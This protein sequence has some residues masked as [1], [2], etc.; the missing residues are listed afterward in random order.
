MSPTRDGGGGGGEAVSRRGSGLRRPAGTPA[1]P[2]DF[3]NHLA[4][5]HAR[6]LPVCQSAATEL[7]MQC[8]VALPILPQ[9]GGWR[10]RLGYLGAFVVVVVP[11]AREM[12]F[13]PLSEAPN[14]SST[15]PRQTG[16]AT[17]MQK[18]HRG[19]RNGTSPAAIDTGPVRR[20][21][22]MLAVR[23]PRRGSLGC[24]GARAWTWSVPQRRLRSEE[25]GPYAAGRAW[26]RAS[27]APCADSRVW[28]DSPRCPCPTP[29]DRPTEPVSQPASQ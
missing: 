28:R 20:G 23:A 26:I 6:S 14:S 5:L 12:P 1:Q 19:C 10:K 8:C 13:A 2:A 16:L 9:R 24:V 18:I 27:S 25:A 17:F 11:K 21:E 3:P 15:R 22:P 4:L 7:R 29:A